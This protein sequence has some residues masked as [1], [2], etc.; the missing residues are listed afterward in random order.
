MRAN[1][2]NSCILTGR[3]RKTA[4]DGSRVDEVLMALEILVVGNDGFPQ[5]A[6]FNGG[7]SL[8]SRRPRRF[9]ELQKHKAAFRAFGVAAGVVSATFWARKS[10]RRKPFLNN[11]LR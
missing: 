2:E 3:I 5:F 8:V 7:A 11:F 10:L 9:F 6:H 1:F 4:I